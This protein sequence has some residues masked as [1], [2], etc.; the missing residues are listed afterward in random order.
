MADPTLT[1]MSLE[2]SHLSGGIDVKVFGTNL[3]AVQDIS[4]VVDMKNID[5]V[6]SFSPGVRFGEGKKGG[7]T[8]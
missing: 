2:C 1:S 3:H 6:K 4:V 8:R 5:L 7:R